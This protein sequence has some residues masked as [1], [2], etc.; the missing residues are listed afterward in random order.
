MDKIKKIIIPC[1]VFL[2]AIYFGFN[3]LSEKLEPA[4]ES[5]MNEV[6]E[7]VMYITFDDGPSQ[8]TEEILNILDEYD[9]KATFFVTGE[10]P[11][12]YDLMNETA[13]RGH[14]LAIHTFS[15][16][17]SKL[18]ESVDSYFEDVKLVS[19][20]ISTE[21]GIDSTILRFPGGSSNTVSRKYSSGIMSV[22]AKEAERRGYQYFDWN[23]SNGDGN[24]NLSPDS[25]V[26]Q[27]KREIKENNNVM[28]LMHDG[29][30]N[31]NTV[32]ALPQILQFIK[33]EGYECKVI[34]STTPVFH[35]TIAN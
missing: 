9:I 1:S 25:L 8:N 26:S 30:G 2:L 10:N 7:K 27:A 13:L 4:S 24:P 6:D 23:A 18:Y 16:E 34:D 35:H 17:Y 12:S 15:H 28:M 32:K 14:V 21:T 29:K 19:D 3:Y 11:E 22:L 20:L 33:D 31:G 5:V